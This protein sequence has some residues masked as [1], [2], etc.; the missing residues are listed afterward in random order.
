M[1]VFFQVVGVKK[2]YNE[3]YSYL[4]PEL[5]N[6]F[7][8]RTSPY[9][10]IYSLGIVFR[11]LSDSVNLVLQTLSNQMLSTKSTD[12]PNTVQIKRILSRSL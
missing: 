11:F 4:A 2:R 6:S 5:R 7:D 3:K 1:I 12:R 9:T 8:T 10:D